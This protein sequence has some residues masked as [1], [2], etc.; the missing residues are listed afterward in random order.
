MRRFEIGPFDK[1]N[2]ESK[3][4]QQ[5]YIKLHHVK[6]EQGKCLS[7]EGKDVRT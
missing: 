5:K 1:G 3:L 7:Q 2:K 6:K 4:A